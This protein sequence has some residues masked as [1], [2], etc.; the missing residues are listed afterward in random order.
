MTGIEEA[1]HID[2][3]LYMKVADQMAENMSVHCKRREASL[4]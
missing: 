3:A 2:T 1:Y 4:Y